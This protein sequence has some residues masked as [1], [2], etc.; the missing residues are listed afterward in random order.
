MPNIQTI[1]IHLSSYAPLHHDSIAKCILSHVVPPG[2]CGFLE[3]HFGYQIFRLKYTERS[4]GGELRMAFVPTVED[5]RHAY[6]YIGS[7]SDE[8]DYY[9]D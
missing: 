1:R 6:L 8:E 4:V 2:Q 3:V 7:W 9:T 5:P